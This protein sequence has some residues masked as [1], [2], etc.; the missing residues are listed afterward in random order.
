MSKNNQIDSSILGRNEAMLQYPESQRQP[1]NDADFEQQQLAPLPINHRENTA[2]MQH[3]F[4]E[5]AGE[6]V[7]AIPHFDDPPKLNSRMC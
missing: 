4:F 6:P 7:C 1:R 2:E 5:E 3:G